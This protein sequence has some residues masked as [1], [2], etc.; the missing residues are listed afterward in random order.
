ML[1]QRLG[2]CISLWFS[3][4]RVSYQIVY[5]YF[6][7]QKLPHPM[8]T[9]FGGARALQTDNYAELAH[10]LG[11]RLAK[12]GISVVT[13]GGSGIMEAASCGATNEKN[14]GS[15]IGI[16][17][18]GLG[19][20]RNP[21]VKEYF[22]LDYFFARRWLL[23]RYSD[24]FIVFPGGY[25]TLDELTELLTLIRTK[26]LPVSPIVLIGIEY[27]QPF[28]DWLKKEVL[29]HRFIIEEHLEIF[30]LTD[31]IQEAFD[32]VHDFCRP[33]M[34]EKDKKDKK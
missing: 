14:G 17:V 4:M 18:K 2:G 24:G 6:R 26:K 12:A 33:I 30:I 25:G 31:D 28:M 21:C 32:I 7:L 15:S 5:G 13:G 3:L 8:V 20:G 11:Q 22:K 23:T 19:E 34:S 9:I 16:G 29:G 27:W 10:K 1:L